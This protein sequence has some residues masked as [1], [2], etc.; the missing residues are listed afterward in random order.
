MSQFSISSQLTDAILSFGKPGDVLAIEKCAAIGAAI[1]ASVEL[2]HERATV[3]ALV[4]FSRH[5][6]RRTPQCSRGPSLKGLPRARTRKKT[7]VLFPA[8]R[9]RGAID[10]ERKRQVGPGER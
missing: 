6:I 3:T 9:G 2:D 4:A 1:F 8:L 5:R 10:I 7:M